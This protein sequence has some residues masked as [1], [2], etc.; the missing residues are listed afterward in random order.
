[1]AQLP[2]DCG[3]ILDGAGN[4]DYFGLIGVGLRLKYT[5]RAKVQ[6]YIPE[7]L[8]PA[9]MS[10][11]SIGPSGLRNLSRLWEKPIEDSFVAWNGWSA[12]EL[13]R[14]FGR[15]VSFADTPLWQLMRRHENPDNWRPLMTEVIGGIWEAQAGIPKGVFFAHALGK[16]MRFPFIDERLA[17]FVHQ[18]PMELKLD[19][20][21]LLA[22]M[23]K[24]L[25]KA[26]V[27]KP[28]SGFIF[29]LN[30]LFHN[31]ESRW[32]D[33]L[34]GAGLLNVLPSWSEQP[35]REL[36]SKHAAEPDNLKW[37][38]RLYALCLLATVVSMKRQAPLSK[39]SAR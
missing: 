16:G 10:L 21:I 25:P 18:L 17:G 22:Y 15:D 39:A 14:L 1:M 28:K 32:A 7:S 20:R 24:N 23:A 26:I 8:W 6:T 31:P 34:L 12:P 3:V 27:D 19:K 30:R 9:V 11:M 37:Q 36:V 5:L 13:T 33:E 4:D 38:H 35:I 2:D 29:D